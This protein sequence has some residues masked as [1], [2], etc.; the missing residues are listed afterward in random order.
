MV[1]LEP[2]DA[3]E[4]TLVVD[5][6]VDILL[7]GQEGV[8]RFPVSYDLLDGDQLVAEHGFSAVVTVERGGSRTSVLYDGGLS[9]GGLVHNMDMMGIR[10]KDLRAIVISHGHTDH[11]AGLEGVFDRHGRMR[12]PLVIHPGAWRDRKVVFPTGVEIHLPPPSRNDLER[13]GLEIIEERGPTLLVDGCVLVSGQVTRESAFETGFPIHKAL[14]DG[15]WEPDPLILDDQNVIVNV[16]GKGLV[17]LSGC[18]HAG[19]VNVCLNARRLTGEQRIVGLIGGFHLTGAIFEPLIAPTIEAITGFGVERVVPAHC[20]GWKA[21]HR[22][23]ATMPDAFAQP[24][25]GTVFRF[26]R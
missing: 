8:R 12:L 2:V 6:Y 5:T 25:V 26:E 23:A 21:V 16:R 19:V 7:A 20:T 14:M 3:V 18:S 13:E 9:K 15:A 10:P 24:S 4:V 1:N 17:I 22:L 11:Y